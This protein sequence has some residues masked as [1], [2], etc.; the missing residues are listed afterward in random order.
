MLR[1]VAS[2]KLVRLSYWDTRAEFKDKDGAA[3]G[4]VWELQ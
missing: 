3:S 2:E 4:F 1:I